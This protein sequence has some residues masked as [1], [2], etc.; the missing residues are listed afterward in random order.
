LKPGL[1]KGEKDPSAE[2]VPMDYRSSIAQRK[3]GWHKEVKI[4]E[5]VEKSKKKGKE[6]QGRIRGNR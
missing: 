2:G 6:I 1:K 4:D 3:R 5:L